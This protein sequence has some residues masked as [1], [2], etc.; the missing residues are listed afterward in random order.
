MNDELLITLIFAAIAAFVIFK[1]R[2]V[3]GRRTGHEPP[4]NE[5]A[6]GFGAHER[7]AATDAGTDNV[8]SLPDHRTDHAEPVLDPESPAAAGIADI[9]SLDPNFNAAEFVGGAEGAFRMVVEAYAGGD[10]ETLQQLLGDDVYKSFEAAIADRE[11]AGHSFETH[12][13]KIRGIEIV[14]AETIGREARVTV[15][16]VTEQANATRDAGGELVDGDPDTIETI[17]DLWTF[18]R[19]TGSADPNWLL[20]E[21]ATPE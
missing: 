3:L 11:E 6:G 14:E 9:Q 4:P 2:G 1:L 7:S 18:A 16:F 17:S 12:I 21:T 8:I 19:D 5:S 13:E 20:V 15:L 10:R